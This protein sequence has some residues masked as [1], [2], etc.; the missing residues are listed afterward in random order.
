MDNDDDTLSDEM[1]RGN[2]SSDISPSFAE[3]ASSPA[4]EDNSGVAL[5]LKTGG[6][7]GGQIALLSH[8]LKIFWLSLTNRIRS[9]SK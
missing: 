8:Y 2:I 5:V 4:A 9:K 6:G 3:G 7:G 1:A